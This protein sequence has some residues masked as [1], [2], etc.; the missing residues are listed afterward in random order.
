MTGAR[1]NLP[2][3]TDPGRA[4]PR[5]RGHCFWKARGEVEHYPATQR[6]A[7]LTS[8]SIV[9]LQ[10]KNSAHLHRAW[11]ARTICIFVYFSAS[12]YASGS[13][14]RFG[15]W[16]NA[17]VCGR[18]GLKDDRAVARTRTG[19]TCM[20]LLRNELDWPS[21]PPAQTSRRARTS[22]AADAGQHLKPPDRLWKSPVSRPRHRSDRGFVHPT[23]SRAA[24]VRT[25]KP[26]N[27]I[28]VVQRACR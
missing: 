7:T 5:Q 22:A 12:T 24:H 3:L 27:S 2:V 9:V 17:N 4:H 1:N 14:S 11:P 10:R 26:K 21:E 25:K 16:T 13:A 20:M 19:R 18:S 23:G 8:P 15:R 28:Y 6:R